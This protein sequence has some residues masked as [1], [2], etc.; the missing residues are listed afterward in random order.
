LRR[1]LSSLIAVALAGCAFGFAGGGLNK[2]IHTVSVPSF[3]NDT[4]D[5]TLTLLV[6]QGVKQAME[7]RLGLRAAT[8][9]QA[10]A[11]V[12][13]RIVR[14]DPDEPLA[15]TGNSAAAGTA[16]QVNVTRRQVEMTVD[17]EVINRKTG[18]K[19]WDG[20][21]LTVQGPYDPGREQDGK[22]KAL[23]FLVKKIIDGVHSNW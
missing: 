5:P 21:G 9:E 8:E 16:A 17:V 23:E 11:V 18:D 15:F 20:K 10:D 22:Q 6:T 2:D 19:L 1:T 3:T 13:G 12:H 4:P 14:Y 7:S